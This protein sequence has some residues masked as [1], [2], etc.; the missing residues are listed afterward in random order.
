[1]LGRKAEAALHYELALYGGG[2]AG[3]GALARS[4]T[5]G[6]LFAR[7]MSQCAANFATLKMSL[8]R[9][10]EALH[11][12]ASALGVAPAFGSQFHAGIAAMGLNRQADGD[13]DRAGVHLGLA[14]EGAGAAH[15]RSLV[16]R[17]VIESISPIARSRSHVIG[18]RSAMLRGLGRIATRQ[19]DGSWPIPT[20]DSGSI[21]GSGAAPPFFAAYH[22]FSDRSMMEATRRVTC[23]DDSKSER[24]GGSGSV[25]ADRLVMVSAR[26][27]KLMGV[28]TPWLPVRLGN[29][30]GGEGEGQAQR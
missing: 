14:M 27:Q 2:D 20:A 22:G 25:V 24:S 29:R 21:F 28:L 4:R 23:P 3:G 5:S 1:M 19:R 11:L 9:R 30:L 12:G 18:A 26:R 6:G 16:L 13:L 7:Q 15:Q 10:T 17:A 8:G